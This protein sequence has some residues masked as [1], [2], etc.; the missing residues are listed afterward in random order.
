MRF[1]RDEIKLNGSLLLHDVWVLYP[2]SLYRLCS[3]ADA[4]LEVYKWMNI[5]WGLVMEQGGQPTQTTYSSESREK[6][7]MLDGFT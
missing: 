1:T 5:Q 4:E 7:N 6:F 3:R 2:K